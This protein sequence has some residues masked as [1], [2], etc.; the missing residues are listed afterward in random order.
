M[1]LVTTD[2]TK[3][4][5]R[6]L[7]PNLGLS[8]REAEERLRQM[9]PNDPSPRNRGALLAE[10]LV[11]V[12]NPLVIILLIV[13]LHFFHAPEPLFHTG[14]FVESLA[15]QTLVLFVIRTAG[16]LLKSKPSVWLTVNT[17]AVAAVGLALDRK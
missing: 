15:T 14:W 5:V 17:L 9:G 16:N 7:P 2:T 4:S 11:L 12:A 1:S 3:D 6:P 10:L 13:L 8:Q